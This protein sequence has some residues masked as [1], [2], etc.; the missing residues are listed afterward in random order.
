MYIRLY[1]GFLDLSMP[2]LRLR[3]RRLASGT[4][5]STHFQYIFRAVLLSVKRPVETSTT[6]PRRL[7]DLQSPAWGETKD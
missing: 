3:Q 5:G 1:I 4:V 2:L 6:T 7:I